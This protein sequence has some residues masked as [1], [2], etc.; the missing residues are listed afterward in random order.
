MRAAGRQRG[1]TRARLPKTALAVLYTGGTVVAAL[2]AAAVGDANS[3]R[4][5]RREPSPGWPWWS[6][7]LRSPDG[8]GATT[9]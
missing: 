5:G 4:M 8:W 2:A 1:L 3:T 7:S 9:G 6:R